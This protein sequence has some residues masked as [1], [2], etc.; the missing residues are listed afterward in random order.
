MRTARDERLHE[1]TLA[2]MEK[3]LLG[4]KWLWTA[5]LL[6]GIGILMTLFDSVLLTLLFPAA[7]LGSNL[8][9]QVKN[10][11]FLNHIS[12]KNWQPNSGVFGSS[13]KSSCMRS[14][15]S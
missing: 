13:I 6:M 8:R 9:Y 2:Y 3:D 14:S 10:V 11:G 4:T 15:L 5:L 1:L 7:F 12:E